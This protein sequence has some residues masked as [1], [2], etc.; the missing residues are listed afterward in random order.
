MPITPNDK[1][2]KPKVPSIPD[3]PD[4]NG[5]ATP[6]EPIDL[7]TLTGPELPRRKPLN[8]SLNIAEAGV[9]GYAG[10]FVP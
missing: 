5:G 2:N 8:P 1:T 10:V 6:I 7:T 9:T 3:V 4:H